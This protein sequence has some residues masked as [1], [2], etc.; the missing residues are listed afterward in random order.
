MVKNAE[1][2]A[3]AKPLDPSF[4]TSPEGSDRLDPLGFLA[5]PELKRESPHH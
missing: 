1:V 4:C 3:E 2:D 5:L